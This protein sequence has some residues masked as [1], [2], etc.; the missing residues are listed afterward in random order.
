MDRNQLAEKP[1]LT[2]A[3]HYRVSPEKVWHAWT[4]PEALKRW[5]GPDEGKVTVAEVDVRVGGRFHIVFFTLDGEQHDVGGEYK[6]VELNRKLVFSWAWKSTPERESLV[7]L[8]FQPSGGGTDFTML[9]EQFFD[10]TARDNHE[11][12]WTGSLVKL[13]RVLHS[14]QIAS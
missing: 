13:E 10:V 6:T 7:T 2:L 14:S 1:S 3:R 12:G 11:F 5:F 8:T 9:H 4:N